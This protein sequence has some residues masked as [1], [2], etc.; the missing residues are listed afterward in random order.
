LKYNA[1]AGLP[2]LSA[3]SGFA[4]AKGVT[5]SKTVDIPSEPIS[6]PKK[7]LDQRG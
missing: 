1:D 5:G 2:I 6:E 3:I 7:D 4:I